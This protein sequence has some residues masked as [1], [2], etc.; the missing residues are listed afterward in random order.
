[1]YIVEFRSEKRCLAAIDL[2]ASRAVT[3]LFEMAA[4]EAPRE[5]WKSFSIRGISDTYTLCR[6]EH[7]ITCRYA[8]KCDEDREI[9]GRTDVVPDLYGCSVQ[10]TDL[11]SW[12]TL[13]AQQAPSGVFILD[14]IVAQTAGWLESQE[15]A[16]IEEED[17]QT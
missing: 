13:C 4:D 9:F 1:M 7:G 15:P 12:L 11:V 2:S 10:S 8:V 14:E 16:P 5:E 6:P 17:A 3:H